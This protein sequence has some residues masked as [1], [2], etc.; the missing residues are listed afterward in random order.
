[1]VPMTRGWG[2]G[3]PSIAAT[4]QG[5]GMRGYVSHLPLDANTPGDGAAG[6]SNQGMEMRG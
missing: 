4:R 6:G 1:M 2:C 5:M 3:S